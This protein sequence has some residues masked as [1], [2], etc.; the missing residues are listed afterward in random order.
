[1]SVIAGV[2]SCRSNLSVAY[3]LITKQRFIKISFNHFVLLRWL[4]LPRNVSFYCIYL[5]VITNSRNFRNNISNKVL[6]FD[7]NPI[8]LE[9][10]PKPMN[11]EVQTFLTLKMWRG[12]FI[13]FTYQIIYSKIVY[14]LKPIAAVLRCSSKWVFLKI[15]Q[16]SLKN[17]C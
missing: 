9:V 12:F 16:Y 11:I 15:F 14:Y 4:P 6:L 10:L 2:K 5:K 3:G 7:F 17:K 13:K 8:L 1:M